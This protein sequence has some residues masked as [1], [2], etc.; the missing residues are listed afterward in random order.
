MGDVLHAQHS[1]ARTSQAET[2]GTVAHVLIVD[3]D[4]ATLAAASQALQSEGHAT[5]AAFDTSGAIAAAERFGPFDVLIVDVL[6]V[7]A[8]ALASALRSFDDNLRVLYVTN[9]GDHR[10][11]LAR[12]DE[13]IQKPFSESELLDAVSSLLYSPT[14]RSTR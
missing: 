10:P 14:P 13:L 5:V 1:G 11:P 2:V 12:D 3:N 4:S 7:D 9:R 8:L 6:S